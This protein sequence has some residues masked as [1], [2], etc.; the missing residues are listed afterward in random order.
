[1]GLDD[2][3]F[4]AVMAR[5]GCVDPMHDRRSERTIWLNSRRTRPRVTCSA[6]STTMKGRP[7]LTV[8]Q[9]LTEIYPE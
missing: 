5:H 1:M 9:V 6:S 7:T 3:A 2:A 8:L 4:R